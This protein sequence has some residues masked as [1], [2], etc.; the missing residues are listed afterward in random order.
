MD[1]RTIFHLTCRAMLSNDPV[2]LNVLADALLDAGLSD[3]E[4]Q[5]RAIVTA[6]QVALNPSAVCHAI[7]RNLRQHSG[8]DWVV[9]RNGVRDSHGHMITIS[10]A[11][12]RRVNIPPGNSVR[13]LSMEDANYLRSRMTGKRMQF[14]MDDAYLRVPEHPVYLMYAEDLSAG[15][16]RL[17]PRAGAFNVTQAFFAFLSMDEPEEPAMVPDDD[18]G[19][20]NFGEVA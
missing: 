13:Y 19:H 9:R 20:P 12:D 2:R 14:R 4:Q 18:Y 16:E 5:V 7:R 15:V 10:S 6:T 11:M 3:E 8:R 17:D 1:T